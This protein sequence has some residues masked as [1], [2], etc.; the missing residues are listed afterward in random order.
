[1]IKIMQI[2]DF[3]YIESTDQKLM[4]EEACK[5]I[6]KIKPDILVITGDLH[7]Y[8]NDY[9]P[10]KKYI[11]DLMAA[12]NLTKSDVFIVPGNHD[13]DHDISGDNAINRKAYIGDI[14]GHAENDPD[15]YMDY[16]DK[17]IK[18]FKHFNAVVSE[19]LGSDYEQGTAVL[20]TWKEKLN[21]ITL[22]TALICDGKDHQQIIDGDALTDLNPCNGLPTI[23]IGHHDISSLFSSYQDILRSRMASW[24]VSFYA[25]GDRHINRQGFVD[26]VVCRNVK[27]PI[28]IAGKGSVERFDDY[29]EVS[30][31]VYE[32]DDQED[33]IELELFKFRNDNKGFVRSWFDDNNQTYTF[34]LRKSPKKKYL[35]SD[36]VRIGITGKYHG[37]WNPPKIEG[38]VLIGTQGR[39]G[40]KYVW[41]SDEMIFES[42]ALNQKQYGNLRG[43]Q[44]ST[45]STYAASVSSGCILKAS[46]KGCSF[47]SGGKIP[48]KGLLTSQDI[49][50]QNVFMSIYDDD[51]GCHE[52]LRDNKREFSY[53]AQGEPGYSYNQ[54]REAIILTE[55]ILLNGK[56]DDLITR[57]IIYTCGITDFFNALARDINNGVFKKPISLHVSLN[58]VGDKRRIMM[59]VD[60]LYNHNQVLEK[61]RELQKKTNGKIGKIVINLIAFDN[62]EY[63]GFQYSLNE[64]SINKILCVINDPSVFRINIYDYYSE[65]LMT[66]NKGNEQIE[67]IYRV[68]S[69]AGYEV[70]ACHCWGEGVKSS[71]G[72]L[73]SSTEGLSDLGQD[74]CR[75]Y[76]NA[77]RLI[78]YQMNRG[79]D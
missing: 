57:H 7:N 8:G 59:P 35:R 71:F 24:K 16:R 56:K 64:D 55:K 60:D 79:G 51:C 74:G 13:V 39:E 5:S 54:V 42:I 28:V 53:T 9:A 50:L 14:I 69:E 15:C 23:I 4:M 29:S 6:E 18:C 62:Y 1:M 43:E 2:S 41:R 63:K 58:A 78:Q 61:C 37:T 10:F 70:K 52:Y 66:K 33:N 30:F 47:C 3:H 12:G 25:G 44:D 27:I 73:D 38:Y 45:I 77:V 19:V 68:I 17:L 48:Y 32:I 21:I 67:N 11:N 26:D 34:D 65:R 22:N 20:H 72:M 40:I 46:E 76:D 36:K 31:L 49:A 75:N